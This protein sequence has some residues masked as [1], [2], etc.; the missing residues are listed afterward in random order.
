MGFSKTFLSVHADMKQKQNVGKVGKTQLNLAPISWRHIDPY[1]TKK[2]T[3]F[4]IWNVNVLCLAKIFRTPT[5][6]IHIR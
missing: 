6:N 1:A 4:E 2:C 5:S 3:K